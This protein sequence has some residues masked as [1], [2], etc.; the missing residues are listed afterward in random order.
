MTRRA[1]SPDT[2][3]AAGAVPA[4]FVHVERFAQPTF[5]DSAAAF[6]CS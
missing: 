2:T 4:A 5:V 3:K 1:Q 6:A